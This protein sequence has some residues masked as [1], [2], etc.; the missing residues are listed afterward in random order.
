MTLTRRLFL[1]AAAATLAA[2]ALA[3]EPRR[4]G[5]DWLEALA[6][7]G[8]SPYLP[9]SRL[10]E[11]YSHAFYV[12]TAFRGEAMQ[13]MW[14]LSR[15]GSGWRLEL[16]DQGYWDRQGGSADYSWPVS[17]GALHPG[18]ER[19]GP[20]PVGIFNLDERSARHSAGGWDAPGMYKS[21]YIDLHYSGG[22]ASGVAM[23]GTTTARYARLGQPASNG[24]VR[25]TQAAMD[26]VWAIVHPGGAR[27]EASPL[28][29]EVPRYFRSDPRDSMSARSGYV[30]D[31]SL[32]TDAAG[33]LLMK[34]GYRAL[35][36]F[37]RDDV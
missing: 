1:S 16:H 25:V 18:A 5:L 13:K 11:A 22:R 14:A 36:V 33:N 12:N 30:R 37:F 10:H 32:L 7:R 15:S 23:H 8:I 4:F 27:R 3:T 2:P 17:T 21:I 28:W 34:P 24:C 26:A 31:G 9:P 6:G 35:F 20:T 19:A 29:G